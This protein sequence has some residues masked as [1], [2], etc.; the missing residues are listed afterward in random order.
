MNT[1]II[2]AAGI[3]K[4][5]GTPTP[6]QFILIH[7]KP[8]LIHTLECFYKYDS[9]AQI[10]LTLPIEWVS[11]WKD[12][13]IEHNCKVP[14]TIISGGVERYDSIKNALAE[15]KGSII[16]VHDGVRPAVSNRTIQNCIDAAQKNG[17]GVPYLPIKESIRKIGNNTS[18][19]ID[20]KEYVLIQTPQVFKAEILRSAYNI[21]YHDAITD[22]ASLVEEAGHSITLV[23]GNEEN[24]KITT[25]TDLKIAALYLN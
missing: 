22:D 18:M 20:R 4:R 5:M 24:I 19:A 7:G 3:G 9:T 10:L 6:K 12:L 21:P 25:P 13:L 11:F 14:H 17:S 2:T 15:A 1:F 23:L 8:V 16:A